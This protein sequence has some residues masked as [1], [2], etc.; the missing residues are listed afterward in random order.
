[1]KKN[2]VFI[3]LKNTDFTEGRGTMIFHKAFSTLEKAQE[4]VENQFGIYGSPQYTRDK[5]KCINKA[6]YYNGYKIL[7]APLDA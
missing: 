3:V 2:N 4:Y 7:I 6:Y 5:I 1:M